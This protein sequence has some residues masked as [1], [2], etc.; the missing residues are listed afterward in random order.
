ME[1]PSGRHAAA[2]ADQVTRFTAETIAA[3]DA[4]ALAWVFI[5][6]GVGCLLFGGI[7]FAA[8]HSGHNVVATVT[9]EGPCSN[10]TCTV[11]VVYA[12][13]GTQVA[14]VMYG[15]NSGEVHGPPSHR[16]LN[17][18]YD[19]GDETSPTTNDMPDAVWIVFGAAGLACLG[20]G[21][22]FRLRRKRPKRELTV[23]GV[24]GAPADVVV[25][26]ALE[27]A[28]DDQ[29][30]P[31]EPGGSFEQGP[32]C[33]SDESGAITIAERY[34]RWW[35][36][37]FPLLAAIYLG[38][39][40]GQHSR[41]WLAGGHI[42][43]TVAGLIIATAA[44]IWGCSRAW[45]IGLRLGEDGVT[46]RNFLRTYRISWLEVRCFADGSVS[47]GESGRVWA[48]SIVLDDGRV[49]TASGTSSGKR[50]V[51]RQTLAAIRQAAER[52]A[53]PA[54]LTG[55]AGKR[56]SHES[57]A[58]P[59]LYPDPGGQP[60]LRRWDGS[61]WSPFLLRADPAS[62]LPDRGKAPA[63]VWAPL[64]GSEP[65]WHDAAGRIRRAGIAFAAWLGA[66][67]VAA[68][69]TVVLYARDLSKPQADFTLAVLALCATGIALA[70]TFRTWALRK[71]L[72]KIDQ[73]GKAAAVL[74]DAPTQGAGGPPARV[75]R[76][77]RYFMISL[78]FFLVLYMIGMAGLNAT[79]MHTWVHHTTGW[80]IVVG[81]AGAL[82]SVILLETDRGQ[83]RAR[84]LVWAWVPI[85]SLGLLAFVPFLWLAL[86]RRRTRDWVV[87]AAYLAAVGALA[88]F[89]VTYAL[90]GHYDQGGT[91][92]TDGVVILSGLMVIAPAHTLVAF[93]PAA[94][95][96]SWRDAYAA[97][98]EESP[99]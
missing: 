30:A 31:S 15:V 65:Q 50:D 73:A 2:E 98:R 45:R 92:W 27:S 86:I 59:G 74:A 93:S 54:E 95:L 69:V 37:L 70:M 52:H 36:V 46:V 39:V 19:S 88:A 4:R 9:H 53:I 82:L 81:L 55:T 68:A 99:D 5:A 96:T 7:F 97:G 87:L 56:G 21:G 78:V 89:A 57:P 6:L 17:I 25:H 24:G 26:A 90:A 41:T 23:A 42:L 3:R 71:N 60:G 83:F 10:G 28:L 91:A 64:A 43:A 33:V 32:R 20:L 11:D 38:S 44:L 40:F 16:L 67:A 63:E 79:P 85:L 47:R 1:E 77:Q 61:Q 14:A 13:G 58:N 62:G 48:L 8:K 22:W 84:Q 76:D 35:A 51:R 34:P 18:N 75:Y 29:L 49:V 94:G 80:I 72:K 66:T 12:A